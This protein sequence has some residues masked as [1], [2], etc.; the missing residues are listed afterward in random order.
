[1]SGSYTLSIQ[2]IPVATHSPYSI[3]IPL[4]GNRQVMDKNICLD[5]H[6]GRCGC[7][8]AFSISNDI[9]IVLQNVWSVHLYISNLLPYLM[10]ENVKVI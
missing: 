3:G 5:F 6:P 7:Y 10:L 1:M 9:T 8:L 2:H 4:H